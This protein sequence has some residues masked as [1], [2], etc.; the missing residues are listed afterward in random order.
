MKIYSN[1]P[2]LQNLAEKISAQRTDT[3]MAE[4]IV[5]NTTIKGQPFS[6]KNHLYQKAIA[7]DLH[8][9]MC[10]K[11]LSQVG[12]T[13]V[14]IRKA[15]AF[16]VMNPGT[17]CIYTFPSKI[18]KQNNSRPRMKVVVDTDFP[19]KEKNE[20]I[21]NE[22]ILQIGNSFLFISSG[23][24]SDVTSTPADFIV[25]DEYDLNTDEFL[26]L[27]N[28]RLQ[29][30][31][32]KI[33]QGFST[34]TF[35]GFGISK[36]F[37]ISDQ[38]EYFIKCEH[39]GHWHVPLYDLES[40]YIPDLPKWLDSIH[41]I[42]HE[43]VT[44]LDF[45]HSY[46]KCKKCHKPLDLSD[47]AVRD[48]VPKF[49][50]RVN[51][52]GYQIRPFSSNLLGIKYLVSTM[53]DYKKRN[54]ARRGYNTVLGEDYQD[55]NSRMEE[56]VIK[57]RFRGASIPEARGLGVFVGIDVGLICHVTVYDPESN[58]VIEF[59]RVPIEQLENKL[60]GEYDKK[61]K[62]LGGAIDRYP[63]TPNANAIRD[64]SQ[65]RI[66]PIVYSGTKRAEPKKELDGS[67]DYFQCNRTQALDAVKT[68]IYSEGIEF[69]GFGDQEGL[70]TEHL[71]DMVRDDE[72]GK[73]PE[74]RKLNGEDHYF[75][76]LGYAKTAPFIRDVILSTA[77]Q[78]VRSEVL[79]GIYEPNKK[80]LDNFNLIGYGNNYNAFKGR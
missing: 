31:P 43:V 58:N 25:N 79:V 65:G 35:S 29:H 64:R 6:Y 72:P 80:K 16:L 13:E 11:K 48:W 22:D 37:E 52:R 67:I 3:D 62:I 34:P 36:E 70:I 75:H 33:K 27:T 63:Y 77:K 8:P 15:I 78:D 55:G 30:S 21:R 59:Q 50:S 19:S 4:W 53:A 26:S 44:T 76:S 69:Y 42:N 28:S 32:F 20:D 40:V 7:R 2:Y 38:H 39:C 14:S 18:L 56:P 68:A 54:E 74:W 47:A 5:N 1:N 49:P 71:R 41:D 57:S 9:N 17:N 73:A 23:S 10:C 24:E 46:V 12:I 60:F 45:E 61:Y 66:M 51:A